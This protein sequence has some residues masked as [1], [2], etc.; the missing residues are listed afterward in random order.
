MS[1]L[2][3]K[4]NVSGKSTVNEWE[5]GRT[6]PNKSSLKTL[7]IF[8]DVS[9]EYLL[10]GSL[11]SYI[12][13]LLMNEL[14]IDDSDVQ[15]AVYDFLEQTTSFVRDSE[16]KEQK[17]SDEEYYIWEQT[18]AKSVIEQLVQEITDEV[19]RLGLGY[20]NDQEISRIAVRKIRFAM[21]DREMN[22]YGESQNVLFKLR[23]EIIDH[24]SY[25]PSISLDEYMSSNVS[26]NFISSKE[27]YD[28]YFNMK[29]HDYLRHVE[30]DI[31]KLQNNYMSNLKKYTGKNSPYN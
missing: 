22:F 1:E 10:F 7:A 18:Q 30:K 19:V 9:V 26:K 5:K 25:N 24:V 4:I 16:E 23:N 14:L 15:S 27:Q 12:E 21:H 31:I 2:A 13:K 6:L 3:N 28:N 20:E 8:F 29:L 17:Y 11:R